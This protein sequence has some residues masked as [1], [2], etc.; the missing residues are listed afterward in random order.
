MLHIWKPLSGFSAD[1][2]FQMN[3]DAETGVQIKVDTGFKMDFNQRIVVRIYVD[4]DLQ[5]TYDWETWFHPNTD[6]GFHL[7]IS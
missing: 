6:A 4:A 3:P 7:T 1:A 2:N 5:F